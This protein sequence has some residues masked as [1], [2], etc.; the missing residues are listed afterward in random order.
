MNLTV[1]R[2]GEQGTL[3]T[4]DNVAQWAMMIPDSLTSQFL[5]EQTELSQA[6]FLLAKSTLG[7]SNFLRGAFQTHVSPLFWS[8]VPKG[9][10]LRFRATATQPSS[11]F[12]DFDTHYLCF[13]CNKWVPL[14]NFSSHLP[15]KEVSRFMVAS[16]HNSFEVPDSTETCKLFATFPYS[17]E[18]RNFW[19]LH[20][21][22]CEDWPTCC[23]RCSCLVMKTVMPLH[24][25]SNHFCT[26]ALNATSIS[27]GLQT[28]TRFSYYPGHPLLHLY[29]VGRWPVICLQRLLKQDKSDVAQLLVEYT[30]ALGII[31]MFEHLVLCGST[32]LT[33][34][35][36]LPAG[37]R[38]VG[39]CYDS[40]TFRI[41]L[42]H[43]SHHILDR[44]FILPILSDMLELV[45][46]GSNA[47]AKK[48]LLLY[49]RCRKRVRLTDRLGL[50]E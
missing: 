29:E 33:I 31:A 24:C 15:V 3:V 50:A 11:E 45:L 28:A 41:R 21:L 18:E 48:L 32:I 9:T 25:S 16:L 20:H 40:Y 44:Q 26:H 47:T 36:F 6:A 23:P 27:F 5:Q 35:S 12:D 8:H 43:P 49:A 38:H 19:Q 30:R 2:P 10:Q 42:S 14:C 13:R 22:N 34:L 4:A 7:R 46:G 1:R 39:S 17:R 37:L